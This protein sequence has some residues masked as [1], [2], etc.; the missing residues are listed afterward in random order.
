MNV[1]VDGLENNDFNLV[2]SYN[3]NTT[4]SKLTDITI[5]DDSTNEKIT[6]TADN[7]A[8][9]KKS[10]KLLSRLIIYRDKTEIISI[11]SAVLTA[12]S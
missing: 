6:I 2:K 3:S 11:A 9:A 8:F 5:Y 10:R 12:A 4:E 1:N 7:L